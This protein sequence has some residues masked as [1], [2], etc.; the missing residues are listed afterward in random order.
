MSVLQWGFVFA[1]FVSLSL[2][3]S[4]NETDHLS[5]QNIAIFR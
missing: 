2:K 1:T 4:N 3:R 5:K